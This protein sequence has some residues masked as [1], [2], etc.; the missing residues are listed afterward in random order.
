MKKARQAPGTPRTLR[1]D[2]TAAIATDL[3][4]HSRL[5]A[6]RVTAYLDREMAACDI[7][8]TQFSLMCLIASAPDDTL[9]SLAPAAGLNQSTM[10][11]NVDMLVR[12]GLVE[13]AVVEKD[14]R[15]RA[16]WLTEAGARVL[17][18]AIPVWRKAH[19]SMAAR[20]AVDL[21]Q[22]LAV[23]AATLAAAEPR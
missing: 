23:A 17:A 4:W 20:L 14:R 21:K 10:S 5:V 1:S 7:S 11:R 16:V 19:G 13:V 15:R 6:R 9:G 18:G 22:N 2:A 12:A 8:S 3:G